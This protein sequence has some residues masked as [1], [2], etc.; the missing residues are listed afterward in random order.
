MPVPRPHSFVI[1]AS[2]C[3]LITPTHTRMQVCAYS[4]DWLEDLCKHPLSLL[5]PNPIL[6]YLERRDYILDIYKLIAVVVVGIF[7]YSSKSF[8][9]VLPYKKYICAPACLCCRGEPACSRVSSSSKPKRV[10]T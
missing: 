9:D 4:V 3:M 8:F 1:P 7:N 6:S 10:G 2:A 5:V